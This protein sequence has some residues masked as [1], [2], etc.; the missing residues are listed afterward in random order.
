MG[1]CADLKGAYKQFPRAAAQGHLSIVAVW[2]PT[3]EKVKFFEAQALMFGAKAAVPG[4]NRCARAME[5]LLVKMFAVPTANF[6]DDYPMVEF[7]ATAG[8]SARIVGELGDLL[9]WVWKDPAAEAAK[10]K[11]REQAASPNEVEAELEN[12]LAEE[13]L[14]DREPIVEDGSPQPVF[15][16]LGALVDL[17][18][19]F[20]GKLHLRNKPGR[21]KAILKDLRAMELRG[22]ITPAEADSMQGRLRFS[23]SN[24]FGKQGAKALR[25][26]TEVAGGKSQQ[27]TEGPAGKWLIGEVRRVLRGLKPKV[28]DLRKGRRRPS[29]VLTDGACEEEGGHVSVGGVLFHSSRARP[30]WFHWVVPQDLL[31]HWR[32]FLN[33]EQVIH[34]AEILPAAIS[35]RLWAEHLQDEL[36]IHFIDQDAARLNLIR[37]YARGM[38]GAELIDK[39][40]EA[41]SLV[42]AASWIDRVQTDANIGDPASRG[43]LETMRSVGDQDLVDSSYGAWLKGGGA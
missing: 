28:I 32:S 9:G 20:E 18:A 27:S 4:F 31:D 11:E 25:S 21:V 10:K 6:F 2:D 12:E 29:I 38:A 35:R 1:K 14:E 16:A 40:W 19:S 8:D 36:V 42:E 39:F 13:V 24:A 22:A 5:A 43:E 26:L 37:G 7:S 33:K 30:R 34:E 17:S 3:S 23:G 41:D 15:I